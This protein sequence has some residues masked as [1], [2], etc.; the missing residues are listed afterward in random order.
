VG[1]KDL[2]HIHDDKRLSGLCLRRRLTG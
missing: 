2:C 1:R